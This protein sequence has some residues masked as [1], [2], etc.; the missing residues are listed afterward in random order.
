MDRYFKLSTQLIFVF[1]ICILFIANISAECDSGQIDINSA[2]LE[3][4]DEL[5]GIGPA[6]AQAI[7]DSRPFGSVDDLID[8]SGIGEV[9]LNNIKNQGLACVDD[10]ESD[11]DSGEDEIIE[12]N[13]TLVDEDKSDEN[14]SGVKKIVEDDPETYKNLV[15]EVIFPNDIIELTPNSKDIKKEKDKE[16]LGKEDYA[17]YGLFVFCLLL[18]I[19]FATKKYRNKRYKNEFR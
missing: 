19:L 15:G 9:I 11:D 6:K 3:E 14:N 18:L 1:F 13:E 17:F 5:Y 16:K 4:L 2:S 8:V 10:E 12:E 7:I